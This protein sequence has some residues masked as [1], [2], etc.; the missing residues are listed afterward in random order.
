MI[1]LTTAQN[2]LKSVYLNVL[3]EQLN[4]GANAFSGTALAGIELPAGL[5]SIGDKAFA[6]SELTNIV[7]GANVA[8]IG[9]GAGWFSTGRAR[10][11]NIPASATSPISRT[12]TPWASSSPMSPITAKL[13]A[14]LASGPGAATPESAA[15]GAANAGAPKR[16]RHGG[17]G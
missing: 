14:G 7:F 6:Y 15:A 16:G 17:Q 8:S 10:A 11:K 2:A 13:N 1:T 12:G 9:A 5:V 4:I 3:S